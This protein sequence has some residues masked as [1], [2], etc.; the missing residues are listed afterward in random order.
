MKIVQFQVM[1]SGAMY[2]L[3]DEGTLWTRNPLSGDLAWEEVTA[4]A[5]PDEGTDS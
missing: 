5:D 2:A 1:D 3:D 4:E